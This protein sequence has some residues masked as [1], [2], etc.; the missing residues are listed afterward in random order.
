M[1]ASSTARCTQTHFQ[2]APRTL[3]TPPAAYTARCLH[4]PRRCSCRPSRP[5]ASRQRGQDV[6]LAHHDV[7]LVAL[8]VKLRT[9][10]LAV[11]DCLAHLHVD[12]GHLAVLLLAPLAH[13]HHGAKVGL[14]D[15][16]VGQ[17]H[18]ARALG[19]RLGALDEDAVAQGLE[20][21]DLLV[22][23]Q[24]ANHVVLLQQHMGILAHSQVSACVLGVDDA[25]ALLDHGHIANSHDGASSVLL[26]SA[27][28]QQ[29]ATDA[30]GLRLVD[31]DKHTVAHRLHALEL[32]RQRSGCHAGECAPGAAW[33]HRG[34]PGEH[35]SGC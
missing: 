15:V 3:C 23:A 19:L 16:L 12:G 4:R 18:A 2:R 27:A 29:H 22:L 6:R 8:L 7:R 34:V 17:Q 26:G 9:A 35:F 11:H 28:G 10:V 31:L 25:V 20:V 24:H 14:L 33:G 5:P 32:L 13:R 21:R 1:T 30:L